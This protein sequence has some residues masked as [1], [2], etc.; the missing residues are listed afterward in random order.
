MS[1]KRRQSLGS[2][3]AWLL[4]DCFTCSAAEAR[5]SHSLS[6]TRFLTQG[7][8][9][10]RAGKLGY[11]R[12]RFQIDGKA[13]RASVRNRSWEESAITRRP[14]ESL[15]RARKEVPSGRILSVVRLNTQRL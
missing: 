1:V 13:N 15:G 10:L 3:W 14:R 12:I 8:R 4:Y 5:G 7:K 11:Q 2:V 6:I 9:G